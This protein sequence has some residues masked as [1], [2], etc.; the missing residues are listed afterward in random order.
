VLEART[1]KHETVVGLAA[2]AEVPVI[3]G[4]SDF[5]H[6]TQAICDIFTM[7]EHAPAGRGISDCTVVFV[8]DRTNVCSSLMFITTRFGMN[9]IHAAPPAYQAPEEWLAVAR[10]NCETSG[11]QVSVTDDVE[12][13]IA[14]A[15][16]IYTDVWWWYGQEDEVQDRT[17]AFMPR[18]QV[19][20]ELF[21]RA[22]DHALFMHCLPATRG[23]EVTD[24]VIDSERSIVFPQ[25]ENRLHAEKGILV[26][27]TYPTLKQPSDGLVREH[28]RRIALHLSHMDWDRAPSR[29]G[30]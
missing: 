5:N 27:L 9:F 1:L 25:A 28:E 2:D 18:Y 14:T 17:A 15:D 26:W 24:E 30:S 7:R 16:F 20:G 22:P 10:A 8:G 11:G 13:A 3:N 21:G 6:P 12:S 4:L 23:G 19:N 29:E